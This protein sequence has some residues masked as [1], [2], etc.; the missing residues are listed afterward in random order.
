M[1]YEVVWGGFEVVW[2]GLVCFW[3]VWG[4]STVPLQDT[5]CHYCALK[6]RKG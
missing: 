1:C 6:H 2:S 5:D 3:V 4:V